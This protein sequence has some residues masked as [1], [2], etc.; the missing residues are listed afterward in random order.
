MSPQ[1]E[2]PT[3]SPRSGQDQVDSSSVIVVAGSGWLIVRSPFLN[4]D[5]IVVTGV[6]ESRVAAVIAASGVHRHDPLLLVPTGKVARRVELERNAGEGR[7]QSIMQIA[8][9]AAAFFLSCGH[10]AFPRPL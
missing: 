4:V 9:Q 3:Q 8:A 2:G 7:T 6:P 1:P 10:Q 5:H